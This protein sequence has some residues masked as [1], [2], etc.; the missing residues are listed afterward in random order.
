MQVS[1]LL[2]ILVFLNTLGA[3]LEQHIFKYYLSILAKD[4]DCSHVLSQ[5][6]PTNSNHM[7]SNPEI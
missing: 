3:R 7:D 4:V 6:T 5:C 2:K 1:N